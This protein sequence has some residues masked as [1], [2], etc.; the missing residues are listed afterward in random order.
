M[1]NMNREIVRF[2]EIEKSI[3]ELKPFCEEPFFFLEG[4]ILGMFKRFL[5][6]IWWMGKKHDKEGFSESDSVLEQ[7]RIVCCCLYHILRHTPDCDEALDGHSLEELLFF[8]LNP[9]S[10]LLPLPSDS[11]GSSDK[12]TFTGDP[13]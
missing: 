13:I 9:T 1:E 3:Q 5:M 12:T 4:E 7:C 6:A 11:E 2:R 8:G 10:E